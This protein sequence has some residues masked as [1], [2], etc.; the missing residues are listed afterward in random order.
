LN[1]K[2]LTLT[3]KPTTPNSQI[4]KPFSQKA[5]LDVTL[6]TD[7]PQHDFYYEYYSDVDYKLKVLPRTLNPEP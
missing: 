4:P 5:L 3:Q 7:I 1:P 6:S 2:L